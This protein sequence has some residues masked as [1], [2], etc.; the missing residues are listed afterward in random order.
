MNTHEFERA[1]AQY[2]RRYVGVV[3][4]DRLTTNPRLLISVTRCI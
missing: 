3:S 2:V 4:S 1:I